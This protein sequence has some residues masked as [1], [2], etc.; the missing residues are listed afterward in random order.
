MLSHLALS[1]NSSANF[2]VYVAWGSK[3]RLDHCDV[4]QLSEIICQCVGCN[5]RY[6]LT[7][8]AHSSGRF[9][10]P[11]YSYSREIELCTELSEFTDI[12]VCVPGVYK[13]H[14]GNC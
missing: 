13:N 2:L 1:V 9:M 6:Q 8:V 14:T 4:A 7:F 11:I 5:Q 10:P 12:S 3:F